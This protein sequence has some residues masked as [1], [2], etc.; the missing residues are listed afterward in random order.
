MG[1]LVNGREPH[2]IESCENS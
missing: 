1:H 2:H